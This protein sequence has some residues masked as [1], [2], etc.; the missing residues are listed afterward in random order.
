MLRTAR[1]GSDVKEFAGVGLGL[2]KVVRPLITVLVAIHAGFQ[3]LASEINADQF[4][5]ATGPDTSGWQMGLSTTNQTYSAGENIEI[6]A[7]PI[8]V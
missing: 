1:L 4:A 6:V 8:S 7:V 3:C 5:R 2:P